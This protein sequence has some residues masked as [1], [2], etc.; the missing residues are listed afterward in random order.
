MS[1]MPAIACLPVPTSNTCERPVSALAP[2]I[3]VGAGGHGREVLDVVEAINALVPTWRVLGFVATTDPTAIGA[4]SRDAFL[5]RGVAYLGPESGLLSVEAW[6][7]VGIGDPAARA[8]ID[9]QF[10]ASR[11]A[12]LIHPL[13]SLGPDNQVEPGC[14]L[15]AGARLTTNV[16]LGRHVHLNINATVSHDCTVGDFVTCAPGSTV[17]GN[18]EIGPGAY[19]GAAATII[20]GRRIGPG[21]RVGAGAVVV[22]DVGDG[23]T[24]VGV[25]ARPLPTGVA[26]SPR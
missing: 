18:V 9:A 15:A 2:L 4:A 23:V 25:P 10:D 20:Q 5:R 17:C 7:A 19:I 22:D 13:A 8:R 3:I 21:A 26:Q 14:V 6:F 24:V 12:T 1:S 16:M 11:A